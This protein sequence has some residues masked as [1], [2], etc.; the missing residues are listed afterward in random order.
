MISGQSLVD[1]EQ[2]GMQVIAQAEK[3][4]RSLLV[5]LQEN[6]ADILLTDIMPQMNGLSNWAA[7]QRSGSYLPYRFSD[8]LR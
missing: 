4:N 3:W 1:Y 6:P 5:K 2:F 8:G 7:S